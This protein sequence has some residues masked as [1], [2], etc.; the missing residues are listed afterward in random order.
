MDE[1]SANW[2]TTEAARIKKIAN[3]AYRKSLIPPP[4]PPQVV[5]HS[6]SFLK[7]TATL[8]FW[9]TVDSVVMTGTT[10][11][12]AASAVFYPSMIGHTLID[13]VNSNEY[14]ITGYTSSTVVTVDS[15]IAGDSGNAFTLTANGVYRLPDDFGGLIGRP[16]YGQDT[17]SPDPLGLIV[18]NEQRIRMMLQGTSSTGRPM[19]C[20][21]RP[22]A[23]ANTGTAGQRWDM[24]VYPHTDSDYNV[25]IKYHR[26]VEDL[27][28]TNIYPVGA[29]DIG[30]V[31]LQGC[32]AV[33]DQRENDS[34]GHEHAEWLRMLATAVLADQARY[35]AESLGLGVSP[36]EE[37]YLHRRT[38]QI[39]YQGVV[40]E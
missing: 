25:T 8:R 36:E 22:I 30:E 11:V 29:A 14:T 9:T 32:R 39:T 28:T 2:S 34:Q 21:V 5:P 17:W 10:T 33:A 35:T 19:F 26:Q 38:N 37:G 7:P 4:V 12:T 23:A 3:S 40:W 1:T 24:T 20:A 31:I 27:D 13:D 6:W 18:T 15:T 16:T